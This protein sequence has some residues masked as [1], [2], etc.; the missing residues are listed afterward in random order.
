MASIFEDHG[1]HTEADLL[2]VTEQQ[3][4]EDMCISRVGDRNKIL[5]KAKMYIPIHLDHD[6]GG[7]TDATN[8]GVGDAFVGGAATGAGNTVGEAVVGLLG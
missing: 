2:L 5:A 8:Q 4:K 1:V 3:L 6:A 7:G